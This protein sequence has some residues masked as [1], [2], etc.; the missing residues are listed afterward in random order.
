MV[1]RMINENG[2]FSAGTAEV[3]GNTGPYGNTSGCGWQ[4]EVN[5]AR[6]Q[7]GRSRSEAP[8]SLLINDAPL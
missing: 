6:S 2:L 7:L 1:T 3:L 4:F 8:M 5:T